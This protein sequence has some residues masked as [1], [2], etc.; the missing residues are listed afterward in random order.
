MDR[1]IPKEVR[2]K[3]RN[4]KIIRYGGMGAAGIVVISVLISL[5]RTGVKEKDIVFSQVS[6]G[7]IEVSVSASGKVVPAFEEIIN[8]PINTRI[9][10]VYKKG[11]DSVDIGT[12]ILKLDLQSAETD[13]KQK[14]DEEQMRSYKLKQL[15]LEN[16]TKLND[17]E[18][19]IKVSAMQLNR[20][21]VELR[22]EQYLDSLGSGTTDKVRQAELSYN[23]AELEYEQLKQQYAN[24]KEVLDAEYQVQELDFSIFRKT[25]AE[26]KRMQPTTAALAESI[27]VSR[28]TVLRELPAVE[29]WMQAAGAHFV[30]NPGK[31]LL[32]DE[33]PERRD[34]LRTQLNSGDRK[35]LS[36]AERRQQLLTRLLSE[37]EP[38]KT[39]VLA[40]ALGVSESTLSADLDE[41]ETKLHPYR[42]EMFR[43][44]G[45]GV[46]LQGDASSY[47]RVVSA[48]LRSSMPEKELAEVLCGR[49][50]ENEIFS[51]LLDTKTA[52]KVW[53]VLQQ[54]EQEEQ[55]HLPDAGFLALA[56][57]CTLT[58]QQLRQGGDK[59]SAPRGL[60][61]AGNHAARL[62]T[63]LNRAF[64]LTLPPE[65][66]Q[67]L[68]LYLSAYLG[69]EDPWG[70]AQEMEL[71]NLEAALIREMEKALHTDL[72]G[73]TSLRDDLYCHLR[74]M[75]LR[76]EQNIRTE[77]P[78][79]DTIRTAYP[80]LWKATRAACDAVQQ[81]FVLPA[82]S[83]DEAAYLAMHFGAVL[84]QNAMFRLRLR[85]VVACPLGMGSSRFLASRLGNEFPS[86]Q[87]E[88]CCSVRELNA[89]DLRRRK[90]DFIISTVPL[91]LDYPA[92]CIS[93]SLL[94]PDRA[95]LKDAITRYS[96]NRAE[97]EPAVQPV[98]D[99][100]CAG[101]KLQYYAR[102][103]R[104]M[105]GL[106]EHLTIQ[107]VK[108]PGSR[109]ALIHAAAQLFCP[110]EAD[111][112]L[113]EQQLRRRETLG[114]T[115]IKSLYALLLHCRTS[116]VK[117]CRLG[118]LQAQPPVYEPGR[119]V[120]GA[121]VLLA[122]DDGN[123][124]PVEVMQNV[125]GQLI[126]TPRLME[127]LRTSVCIRM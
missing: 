19:K 113:V 53:A 126:E 63:A 111:A 70:S 96:Q 37:Q 9:L 14:L 28:R 42:V 3:E 87:V 33:A 56:I 100:A 67:Y 27:G 115:Y 58:I 12:P 81:Q 7:T 46:W 35:K 40:R 41:L 4:K 121:L 72:S 59:G 57:H 65:E 44:P 24:E 97:P 54:F 117:D 16:M 45:V 116:A 114:D 73:Y 47:R 103:T 79:L 29:Q 118:Y 17:L 62:V 52:E 5:M 82:I 30:R 49:M 69:A 106:L 110:Q 122:P 74:P 125:S 51:T 76:V 83:D 90:I 61:P 102:L 89:A 43:R 22:N 88:G 39:A 1:E 34:A 48:L 71:R 8:S 108:V 127:V 13:Y 68:E 38:C 10:E 18:M 50:P 31:G 6:T 66:A 60:R 80:G 93:P 107:P 123:G 75:L 105:T 78:Q 55:L 23:V 84:E 120:L 99:T 119:I 26:T 64:G 11:G 112:R 109:A 91:E 85:V 101:S 20:K 92:V 36:R 25:L 32:L 124:V 21:K 104:S 77:N 2:N 98:Q 94:E 86:L 15:K 95:V